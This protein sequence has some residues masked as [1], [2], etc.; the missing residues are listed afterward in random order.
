MRT[1][2]LSQSPFSSLHHRRHLSLELPTTRL[3]PWDARPA[4]LECRRRQRPPSTELPALVIVSTSLLPFFSNAREMG[5]IPEL[6]RRTP[7]HSSLVF[8]SSDRR[9]FECRHDAIAARGETDQDAGGCHVLLLNAPTRR[10]RRRRRYPLFSVSLFW[11][12][13]I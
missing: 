2:I 11:F 6:R 4:A 12:D 9:A 1:L 13:W 8:V 7:C 3:R 10:R 5:R